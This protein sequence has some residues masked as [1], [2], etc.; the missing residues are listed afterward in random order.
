LSGKVLTAT[1]KQKAAK[2]YRRDYARMLAKLR[3]E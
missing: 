2:G 3:A 1:Q